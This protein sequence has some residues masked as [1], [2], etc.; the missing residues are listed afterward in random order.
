L[1]FFYGLLFSFFAAR[2][3]RNGMCSMGRCRLGN[4]TGLSIAAAVIGAGSCR[5]S[6][7]AAK[8]APLLRAM[9]E[10]GA[11]KVIHAVYRPIHFDG[12]QHSENRRGEIDPAARPD[13]TGQG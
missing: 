1:S 13:A 11:D 9:L 7:L 3:S 8:N 6:P 4:L 12:E 5:S 2:M 10:F